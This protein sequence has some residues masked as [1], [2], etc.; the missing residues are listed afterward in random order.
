MEEAMSMANGT[1]DAFD[2][3]RARKSR[4]SGSRGGRCCWMLEKGKSATDHKT[5]PTLSDN[6]KCCTPE[7][8][9]QWKDRQTLTTMLRGDLICVT[10]LSS[11]LNISFDGQLSTHGALKRHNNDS[12]VP[13]ERQHRLQEEEQVKPTYIINVSGRCIFGDLNNGGLNPSDRILD[14]MLPAIRPL[15]RPIPLLGLSATGLLL[16]ATLTST[17]TRT[18]TSSAST[19]QTWLMKKYSPRHASWP[20]NASDFTRQDSSSDSSFYSAPRFV[21]HIDDAAIASLRRY[22]DGVLPRKGRILDFC[23]SWVSHYPEA[24]EHAA[25]SGELRI[26]GMGMNEP[27]LQANDVLNAGRVLVDLNVNPDIAGALKEAHAI[28]DAEADQLD[29]STNVVSTDYLTQPVEVLRSLRVATRVGGTVHLTISNRCFPTKAISRWLRVDE[30]ERLL[31]VGDFL[32][33]AGWQDIEIVELSDG[34]SHSGS[35]NGPS[36]SG[37]QGLM[38]WM[39]MRRDPLWVLTEGSTL[40]AR[41]HVISAWITWTADSKFLASRNATHYSFDFNYRFQPTTSVPTTF[42]NSPGKSKQCF[43]DC[44]PSTPPLLLLPLLLRLSEIQSCRSMRE[45]NAIKFGSP[46]CESED[47][48]KERKQTWQHA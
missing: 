37:L 6:W 26:T 47:Y 11:T 41:R 17:T 8:T 1:A 31:M 43:R 9:L 27:E 24:I 34:T 45:K 44:R 21:T 13:A 16:A 4:R 28:G 40:N 30:Q 36:Q 19:S 2:T 18:M 23:S 12:S 38:S 29:V 33:F 3:I 42:D 20:Y 5:L 46:N 15:L 39:G 22:Y 10:L 48:R 7:F 32:H 25:A 35:E 14:Q